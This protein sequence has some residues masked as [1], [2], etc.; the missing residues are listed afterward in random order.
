MCFLG[1]IRFSSGNGK[2]KNYVEAV[3]KITDDTDNGAALK[4]R[5]IVYLIIHMHLLPVNNNLPHPPVEP[6]QK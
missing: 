2:V 3:L 1:P 5:Y 4:K 6:G